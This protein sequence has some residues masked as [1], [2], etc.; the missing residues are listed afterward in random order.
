MGTIDCMSGMGIQP[1]LGQVR[2][3]GGL[4][5]R[6]HDLAVLGRVFSFVALGR[7]LQWSVVNPTGTCLASEGFLTVS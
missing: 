2:A 4:G 6:G 3:V 1:W 7:F 5:Y